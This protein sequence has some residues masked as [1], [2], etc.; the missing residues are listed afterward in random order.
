[1]ESDS[2]NSSLHPVLSRRSDLTIA[3]VA[4][5]VYVL[6][7]FV[8]EGWL[9]SLHAYASYFFEVF[10]TLT[11][12]FFFRA[13]LSFHFDRSKELKY[14]SLAALGLGLIV[15]KLALVIPVVIPFDFTAGSLVFMLLVVAP[16]LEEFLFRGALWLAFEALTK[17]R[18][19]AWV[20][21]ALLFS[22]G[23]FFAYFKVPA[24]YKSFVVYQAAY[25]LVLGF[26][27]GRSLIRQ[28][29]LW[30]TVFLHFWFNLGFYIAWRLTVL[31]LSTTA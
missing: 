8:L 10:F 4:L 19:A 23:H 30:A 11:V 9:D 16:L 5:A 7:R 17:S 22:F 21:S 25:T 14:E 18:K 27:W 31:T 3:I 28:G 2:E 15:F 20:L 24:E 12:F 29:S 26:W 6:V 1:M 13:P